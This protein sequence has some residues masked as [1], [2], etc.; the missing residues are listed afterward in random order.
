MK[1]I[2]FEGLPSDLIF[3]T[4]SDNDFIKI[5]EN[6]KSALDG[7]NKIEDLIRNEVETNDCFELNA[8]S[9]SA[10]KEIKFTIRNCDSINFREDFVCEESLLNNRSRASISIAQFVLGILPSSVI[11]FTEQTTPVYKWYLNYYKKSFGSEFLGDDCKLGELINGIRNEDLTCLTIDDK[12]VDHVMSFD[13]LE[14]IPDYKAALIEI[15]RILRPSGSAL[16]TF[17]FVGQGGTKIRA[18]LNTDKSI[19]HLM[20]PEY[21]G[22]PINGNEGIL[23]FYHFGHDLISDLKLIGFRDSYVLWYWSGSKANFGGLQPY[24]IAIK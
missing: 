8:Y 1:K 10:S 22:D 4:R 18:K 7:I 19:T 12:S 15:Y 2:T 13:V 23:C 6:N 9:V 14:H 17:P 21:H 20:T 16:L 24:I 5:W 3:K 11:Y